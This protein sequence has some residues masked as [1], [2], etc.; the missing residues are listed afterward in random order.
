MERREINVARMYFIHHLWALLTIGKVGYSTLQT[1]NPATP[2]RSPTARTTT[3]HISRKAFCRNFWIGTSWLFLSFITSFGAKTSPAQK[4]VLGYGQNGIYIRKEVLT[5][6]SKRTV[7][8]N[9]RAINLSLPRYDLHP[10][11]HS[12][13]QTPCL[14]ARSGQSPPLR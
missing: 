11:G 8:G 10:S 12:A 2:S 1:W 13:T 5:P 4:S 6:S 7:Y 3:S 14:R 9:H